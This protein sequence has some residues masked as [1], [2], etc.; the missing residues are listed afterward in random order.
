MGDVVLWDRNPFSV[1]ARADQVWIDGV[2]RYDRTD[3]D[4]QPVT[5]FALGTVATTGGAQ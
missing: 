5:D 3:P 2:L 1:Y 4:F